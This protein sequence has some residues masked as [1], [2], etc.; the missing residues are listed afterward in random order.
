MSITLCILTIISCITSIVL[1]I[2]CACMKN[3][4]TYSIYTFVIITSLW[5]ATTGTTLLTNILILIDHL[6]G[7]GL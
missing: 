5:A 3:G 6:K 1:V 2:M 7:G 4:R